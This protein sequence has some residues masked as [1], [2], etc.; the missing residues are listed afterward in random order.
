MVR[1]AGMYSELPLLKAFLLSG[2]IVALIMNT[3]AAT[4]SVGLLSHPMT[5]LLTCCSSAHK[6]REHT[7]NGV[8]WRR[9]GEGHEVVYTFA[10]RCL[11][12]IHV[13]LCR[14]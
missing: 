5:V 9:C 7:S 10:P 12:P 4:A 2:L 13:F 8:G 11:S 3:Q 1:Q 14:V 6:F